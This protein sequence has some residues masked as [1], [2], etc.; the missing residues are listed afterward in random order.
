VAVAEKLC[1]SLQN[2]FMLVRVQSA[3]PKEKVMYPI[4]Y[5]HDLFEENV[6]STKERFKKKSF[7]KDTRTMRAASINNALENIQKEI[8]TVS[9]AG[10]A[11]DS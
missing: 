10:R 8:R 7:E 6:K 1:K 11:V 4:D 5:L 9:S 2:S 3:T